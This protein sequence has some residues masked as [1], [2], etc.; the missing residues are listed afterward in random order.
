MGVCRC[1]RTNKKYAI[2]SPFLLFDCFG[3]VAGLELSTPALPTFIPAFE[4]IPCPNVAFVG[5]VDIEIAS[6]NLLA[7]PLLSF[8]GGN[9]IQ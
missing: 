5:D 2:G 7:I 1:Y 8:V 4:L 6:I 9:K 3:L